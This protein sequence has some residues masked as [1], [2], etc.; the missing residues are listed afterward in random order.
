M[1]EAVSVIG[2]GSWGTA[3]AHLLLS[4]GVPVRLWSYDA[5]VAEE[6]ARKRTNRRFLPGVRLPGRIEVSTDLPEVLRG[7][8]T[9]LAVVPTQFIRRT[10]RKAAAHVADGATLVSAAKGIEN[11]TLLTT[12]EIFRELLDGKPRLAVLSG[13][14]F[15]AEVSRGVPTA[16]TLAAER[17]E[18]A[19]RLQ[20][21]FTTPYFRVYSSRDLMG[22]ELG[23]ALKNVMAIASGI[24]DGLG[25]GHSSRA[26]L[27]TRGLAEMTRL[28]LARGADPTT[29][30]GL[31]GLGDLVLTCTGDLSRNRSVGLRLGAGEKI[32]D[33]LAGMTMVAEGVETARS[34]YRLA[35]DV[36][37]EMPI[38]TEV[39]RVLYRG[40]SPSRAVRELMSRPLTV[41][42]A[43]RSAKGSPGR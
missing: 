18:D 23:G 20:R 12:S 9:I 5:A 30:S 36:G 22:V 42:F 32:R 4:K 33:I 3:L 8:R 19:E 34:A 29:F 31:S 41:E 38:V 35:R 37:V 11:R 25:L 14:S 26:A 21:L 24:S 17:A 39:Y 15:A 6:I 7:A 28:G 40:K 10:F 43:G 13:P 16:V 27:I 2:A 1:H